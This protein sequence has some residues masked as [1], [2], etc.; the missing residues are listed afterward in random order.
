MR[1]PAPS[2]PDPRCALLHSPSADPRARSCLSGPGA[3]RAP[4]STRDPRCALLHTHTSTRGARSCLPGPGAGHAPDPGIRGARSCNPPPRTRGARSSD[5]PQARALRDWRCGDPGSVP[6]PRRPSHRE[7]AAPRPRSSPAGSRGWG[8][9]GCGVDVPNNFCLLP[10][11]SPKAAEDAEGS[12][13]RARQSRETRSHHCSRFGRNAVK[14]LGPSCASPAAQVRQA[15]EK[16]GRRRFGL[17]AAGPALS[18]LLRPPPTPDPA[19][20]PGSR[21]GGPVLGAPTGELGR[22]IRGNT[23]SMLNE[24]PGGGTMARTSHGAPRLPPA[25]LYCTW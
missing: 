7:A 23:G 17:Q 13:V 8:G 9:A 2:Y 25:R 18:G 6:P 16:G 21:R 3:V 12:G 4:D 15:E 24:P 10:S 19:P 5:Q 1:A 11:R 22:D 14:A 20:A